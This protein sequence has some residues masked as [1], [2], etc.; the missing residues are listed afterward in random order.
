MTCNNLN[1]DQITF[2]ADS[3][4]IEHII[5]KGLILS[6]FGKC[7]NKVIKSAN[8]NRKA[9]IKID[10]KSNLF[11][12]SN[13]K[14]DEIIELTNVITAKDIAN[15]LLSLRKFA[16]MGLSI[17]LDNEIL[18][19]FDKDTEQEY[20][21][22]RYEKPNWLVEFTARNSEPHD[23]DQNYDKYSCIAQMITLDE[24]LQQ[25]QTAVQELSQTI[26]D[27]ENFHGNLQFQASEIGRENE[28]ELN[29]EVFETS[30]FIDS[31]FS[32]NELNRKIH[33]LNKVNSENITDNMLSNPKSETQTMNVK[34]IPEG[35][36]L[37]IRL[38]HA[39]LNYLKQ[40]QK[41]HDE[42]KA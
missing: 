35:M 12:K 24:F 28:K 10:G 22:G 42:L 11:L 33:D 1:S 17:H 31:E 2:I 9:D 37:H 34:K 26:S 5:N 21:T 23:F 7:Y 36:L 4:A 16:D 13:L 30:T 18:K 15:N 6:N 27:G 40:L 20:L 29:Q 32:Q 8:K 39:S 38:G 19:I 25:S 3:G 41:N 14:S